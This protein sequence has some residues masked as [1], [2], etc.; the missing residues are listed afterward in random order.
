MCMDIQCGWWTFRLPVAAYKSDHR[1]P[2]NGT[3][4]VAF[5]IQVQDI[6]I[7]GVKF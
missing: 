6:W 2:S 4:E 1:L 5:L 3:L 7:S